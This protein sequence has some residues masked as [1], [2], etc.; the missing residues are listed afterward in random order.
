MDLPAA[1]VTQAEDGFV[2]VSADGFA[3][4]GKPARPRLPEKNLY[5]ALPPD[6]DPASVS[7]VI[8]KLET[9]DESLTRPVRPGE[10]LRFS[11]DPAAPVFYG[12]A[13]NV[14]D[15]MDQAVYARDAFYPESPVSVSGFPQ[16]RKW[17]M[18]RV[19]FSPVLY[20]PVRGTLRVVERVDFEIR[21]QRGRAT[22]S[23][24][25]SDTVMDGAA[26]ALVENDGEARSWYATRTTSAATSGNT[27]LIMTT[28]E[29]Y[30]ES[31]TLYG[32]TTH[33]E[34]MGFTVHVV[35]ETK[36]DGNAAATGWNEVTGQSPDGKAD[37][38]RKWLQDNYIGM[39]IEYVLLI[40]NPSPDW[41]DLPMKSCHFQAYIYP[42]DG[43][44][45][46][47]TGNWDL[48]GNGF[49]GNET[50][51][52]DA[53]GGVDKVPEVY[54]GRIPVYTMDPSWRE[55]LRGIIWKT[56]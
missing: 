51:D 37:R 5:Y 4:S 1:S 48:D 39:Q 54:V 2:D 13:V 33:K 12:D 30:S 32:L 17:K 42:V 14:V 10:A 15:G 40:G 19:T 49:F 8:T 11:A 31:P 20:N 36:L 41:G 44:Y 29:I 25:Q 21:Y 53:V 22:Q 7:I 46:D 6:V 26:L 27:Y 3:Y 52:V 35:T 38:M 34:D 24:A 56:I 55:T 43:Y 23:A 50:N 9:R 28:D 45:A 16:M 47:L 18:V